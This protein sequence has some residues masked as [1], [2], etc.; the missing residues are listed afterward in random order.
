[1]RRAMIPLLLIVWSPAC[2]PK[3]PKSPVDAAITDCRSY[4]TS[5]GRCGLPV[6]KDATKA[7]ETRFA[8]LDARGQAAQ[9][10][11][12]RASHKKWCLD[13]VDLSAVPKGHYCR[14][15]LAV[16]SKC[17]IPFPKRRV[18]TCFGQWQKGGFDRQLLV[19]GNHDMLRQICK[20]HAGEIA[21]D[22]VLA[23][24]G[25]LRLKWTDAAITQDSSTLRF[26][27]Q[28]PLALEREK[29]RVY[30]GKTIRDS[31]TYSVPGQLFQSLS[32]FFSGYRS[33]PLKERPAK[34]FGG[35]GTVIHRASKKPQSLA[36]E[37]RKIPNPKTGKTS[38]EG[39][40]FIAI[41]T[42]RPALQCYFRVSD[43]IYQ[44]IGQQ[45]ITICESVGPAK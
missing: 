19:S 5:M 2:K 24:K 22:T 1:M 14:K 8:K 6:R 4:F 20:A 13:P 11:A 34:Y 41:G 9:L 33:L 18:A 32:I 25:G 26:R 15:L 29:D 37:V 27:Y 21:P 36:G 38:V 45:L 16:Y 10:T 40:F 44:R 42:G 12:W 3:T 28:Q 43:K 35:E 31:V 7:C 23:L 17:G 30:K 39:R